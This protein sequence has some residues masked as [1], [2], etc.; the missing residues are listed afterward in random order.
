MLSQVW[1]SSDDKHNSGDQM[2]L[3][4]LQSRLLLIVLKIAEGKL[5]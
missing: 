5:E 2:L 3:C 1:M 4:D